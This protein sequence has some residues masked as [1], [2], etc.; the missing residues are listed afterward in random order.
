M[1]D[2]ILSIIINIYP[3][4]TRISKSLF[5][6]LNLVVTMILVTIIS[7]DSISFKYKTL[8]IFAAAI[9]LSPIAVNQLLNSNAYKSLGKFGYVILCIQ[10]III[11]IFFFI[12]MI[13]LKN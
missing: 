12:F 8:F 5:F 3:I 11:I 13:S 4:S 10:E 7:I 6:K 2:K 1:C 9:L